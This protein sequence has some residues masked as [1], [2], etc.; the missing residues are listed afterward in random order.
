[1]DTQAQITQCVTALA[2][3]A[4]GH[5]SRQQLDRLQALT[6]QLTDVLTTAAQ[7]LRG[8]MT[9]EVLDRILGRWTSGLEQ[10]VGPAGVG[11]VAP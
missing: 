10:P 1:M 3:E 5:L 2:R 4:A 11:V 7:A 8:R 9:L 6:Q